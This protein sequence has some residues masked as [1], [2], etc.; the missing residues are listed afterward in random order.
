MASALISLYSSRGGVGRTFLAVNLAVDLLLETRDKALLLDLGQPCSM[1]A[2]LFLDLPAV[3]T[4]EQI[5]PTADRLAPAMLKSY[6]TS[7]KSGLDA[8]GLFGPRHTSAAPPDPA[9]LAAL[10]SRLSAVYAWIVVDMGHGFGPAAERVL[11]LSDLILVPAVPEPLAMAHARSDLDFLRQRNYSQDT[12]R[13][14]LNRVGEDDRLSREAMEQ[15][16]GRQSLGAVPFDRAAAANLAGGRTYP[17]DHP[18]HEVTKAFDALTHAIV[19]S[20]GPGR[21]APRPAPAGA[22]PQAPP[23]AA[24]AVDYDAVK[25]SLHQRLLETFDLK[26][27]DMEVESDPVKREELRQEV[28]R[29]IIVLLDESSAVR[30]RE[31]RDRL[32]R[33]LLQ[34]VLGLGLLEDLLADPSITEIMVNSFDT[35]YV[36]RKGLIETSTRK[37][38]SER[39]LMRVIE[40]I[41]APLGRKVDTSTPMVDARL[42]DGSRVNAIIPPLAVKG[43]ALTIR[44]FPEKKLSSKDLIGLGT[45]SPQMETFLKAAV[46]ARLNIL[47][48]GGT[49]SGKTTLLNILSEFIPAGERIITVEDSA[50]LKLLQPHVIT[51]EGRPPNIEGKGEVTIRDLVR[52]CLRMRP[53]RIVVGEC[54]GSEALDMLQAMNT[55]HDGSLTTIHANSAREALSRLETLV[56]YAGYELTP[57]TIREQVTGAIDLIIQIKRFKDGKRRIVQVSE[58]TGMEVD[59]ITLGDIFVFR[60]EGAPT[61]QTVRGAYVATGYIPRCLSDFEDRGV[62]V[63]REI[64]WT[65]AAGTGEGR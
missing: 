55:G 56:M 2:A 18:R 14:V 42:P 30:S 43:A 53:D 6:A 49:G 48:S 39:H 35:I 50:E 26:Y 60:Q 11:D 15:H 41:V 52:N 44:K 57:K 46:L 28:T 5:L 1:D 21:A 13:L 27:A 33:E 19:T 61:P 40:R 22:A 54:R 8:L 51:L 16:V 23:P 45:L 62:A 24:P 32:V 9:A 25:R 63:P 47:I 65:A 59:I 37:F 20:L 58:V 31:A 34:D 3:N 7:H 10:L 12:V 38:L 17:G 29:Q 4:L 64:F 36:E